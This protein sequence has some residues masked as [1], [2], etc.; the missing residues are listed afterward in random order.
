[1]YWNK[2]VECADRE[3]LRKIQLDRLKKTVQRV[4]QNVE[5]YR[6]RM[7]EAGITPEDV[8]SL[9]D[10]QYL[11]FT[12]KA[13]LRDNYPYG[14]FSSPLNEIVRIHAS[15]GTTGKPTV[16]GYTHKDI[17]TWADLAGRCI[18][19]AGGNKSDLV[20][21]AYGYGLFTGGLGLHYGA[22]RIGASVIPM[23]SG[24]T[25][26]QVMLMRDF[27][28][29]I[30]CCTPSY[31]LTIGEAVAKAGIDPAELPLR[32]GIF[33]AEPWTEGMRRQIQKLLGIRAMDIYGLSEIMGPGVSCECTYQNGMHIHEDCFY[34]EIVD[35]ET[36]K[37]LPYG[38][39]GE[40]VFTT[41]SKEGMPLVRYRT[42]D[43]CYLIPD[44][45]ECGR[46]LVRM[47][48]VLGRSDDML[49]IRGVNV[50]PSQVE[51]VITQFEELTPNYKIL[52]G[53]ENNSDTFEVVVELADG[54]LIDN[55]RFVENLKAR[56]N[57]EMLSILGLRC[58]LKFVGP[59][60]LERSEG[61]AVRV[62]D[63]RKLYEK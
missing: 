44:V 42:K 57:H 15:S 38:E 10:L 56:V 39:K 13:D 35:P 28:S 53:R 33:G 63:T 2:I 47:S 18:V 43:I 34:P 14:M 52:V 59:G 26:K 36:L 9:E 11:P 31:A 22:E 50:F 25:Q 23:S 51:T 27:K 5:T 49:I 19:M 16:V 48:P 7:Q 62:E 55:I 8:Q 4:Y 24:N 41:I 40:L 20:Q 60:T 37:P 6:T 1:M 30:L 29:T 17:A 58:H 61:K 45:C 54:L 21:V 3:Y 12:T 46:T 32:I